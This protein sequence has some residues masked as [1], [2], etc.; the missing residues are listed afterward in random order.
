MADVVTEEFEEMVL[1]VSTD[2]GTSWARMAGITD[3]TVTRTSNL[4]STEVPDKD[5]ETLPHAIAKRVRSLDM[6][7]S[8]EGIWAQSANGLMLDWFHSGARNRA[9]L[10]N[11]KAA[12]GETETEEGE[13][14]LASIENSRTKGK[15]VTASIELQFSGRIARTAKA[16]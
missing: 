14:I 8:G 15:L 12:T 1:E 7:A 10:R 13:A 16:S 11:T 3:V 2:G 5:D 4:D 6:S 9:R